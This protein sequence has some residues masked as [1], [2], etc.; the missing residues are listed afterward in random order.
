LFIKQKAALA[1]FKSLS[2]EVAHRIAELFAVTMER[3]FLANLGSGVGEEREEGD[4]E[5]SHSAHEKKNNFPIDQAK[6]TT[7]VEMNGRSNTKLPN[8]CV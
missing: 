6:R 1:F 8:L 7:F 2:V 3:I 5:E 4:H